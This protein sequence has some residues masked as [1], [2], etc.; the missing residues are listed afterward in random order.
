MTGPPDVPTRAQ[1]RALRQLARGLTCAA[2]ARELGVKTST[3]KKQLKLLYRRVGVVSMGQAIAVG[4]ERGWLVR[5]DPDDCC[6]E[7]LARWLR[8][9]ADAVQPDEAGA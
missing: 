5:A 6:R 1:L 8:E 7:Y 2:T 4:Y 9:Q 3:V